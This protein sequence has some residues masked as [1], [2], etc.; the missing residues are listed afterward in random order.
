[1]TSE[2]TKPT[3]GSLFSG[4]G[5]ID[6]GLERAGFEISWQVEI[7]SFCTK[8]LSAH[9]PEVKRYGDIRELSG[10]ELTPVDLLC[11]GF[12]CQPF[13]VAGQRRGVRDHR[14]LWPE[15]ARLLRVVRPQYALIENVPG[16]L[17]FGGMSEI[18]RDLAGL[19]YDA[20]WSIIP[21]AAVGAPHLRGRVFIIAYPNSVGTY[22]RPNSRPLSD[23]FRAVFPWRDKT[24]EKDPKSYLEHSPWWDTEPELDR[25]ADG[26]P[27]RMDR[28]K[29][30][31]NSVVPQV[32]EYI[33]SLLMDAMK[34]DGWT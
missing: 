28:L 9:W 32:A 11:G 10:G 16:L 1:M 12:P 25:V 13:S 27:L 4:I 21:A 24:G 17:G 7:D 18:L 20:E 14:W 23:D 33:G 6:L 30:L 29:S 34:K 26:V 5:G 31:G 22:E 3:V 2:V 8:V 19:R 15:F